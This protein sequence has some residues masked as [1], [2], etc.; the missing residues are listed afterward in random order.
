[1][2]TWGVTAFW[3]PRMST[4]SRWKARGACCLAELWISFVTAH[5]FRSDPRLS[6]P[7]ALCGWVV[8]DRD[9][10]VTAAGNDS[11]G[12]ALPAPDR[13]PTVHAC[14]DDGWGWQAT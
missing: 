6:G 10:E 1:V 8:A 9:I 5:R 3:S 4:A 7:G 12:H 2:C 14:H 13:R 11:S